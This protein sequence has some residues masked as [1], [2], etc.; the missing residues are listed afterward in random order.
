MPCVRSA[1]R[2]ARC[3]TTNWLTTRPTSASTTAASCWI[4]RWRWPRCNTPTPRAPTS[5]RRSRK[6]R[7]A[8][9]CPCAAPRCGRGFL[10]AS[11]RR[12][13]S[14][15]PFTRTASLSYP[16]TRT[17]A[18]TCWRWPRRTPMKS[19]PKSPKSYS[20]RTTYGHR[21]LQSLHARL[22]LQT[23]KITELEARSYLLE[24]VLQAALHQ[25]LCRYII[26]PE[27]APQT[28]H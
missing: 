3:P 13:S 10:I 21:Q 27:S 18:S 17:S 5:R 1:K 24:V 15:R 12:R 8:R 16:L 9:S 14:W 25:C 6:L 23:K 28:L 20:V 19:P 4:A 7:R 11:G 26:S 2:S 22:R